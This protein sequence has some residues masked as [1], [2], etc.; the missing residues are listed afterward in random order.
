[1]NS[2]GKPQDHSATLHSPSHRTRILICSDA[3]E[4]SEIN[5]NQKLLFLMK[6]QNIFLDSI[7]LG[8]CE[9]LMVKLNN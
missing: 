8:E 2:L 6:R 5:F 1:M 4:E 7:T 3:N 9:V